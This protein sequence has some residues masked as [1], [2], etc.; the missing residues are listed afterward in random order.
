MQPGYG[1]SM[2]D[3][4]S[5][6]RVVLVGH[7]GFDSSA[8]Q[9]TVEKALPDVAVGMAHNQNQLEQSAD[10]G[11]LLLINRV[12]DGRFNTTS[13]YEMIEELAGREDPPKMMLVSNYDDAQRQAEQ[14]GAMPGFGK[15]QL[16]SP[17]LAEKLRAA[18]S[19]PTQSS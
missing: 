7:C 2:N 6:K 13:C 12:L 16:G 14:A 18:V 3:S 11:S 15:N 8:I 9:R 10:G 5:I 19:Q 4:P 17:E 1:A